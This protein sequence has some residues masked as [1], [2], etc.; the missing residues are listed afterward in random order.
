MVLIAFPTQKSVFL[1]DY[2]Q[3]FSLCVK[4]DH[5]PF[6]VHFKSLKLQLLMIIKMLGNIEIVQNSF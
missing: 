3:L 6:G 1:A 2:Q 4:S 5:Y